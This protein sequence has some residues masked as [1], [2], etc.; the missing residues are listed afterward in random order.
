MVVEELLQ[1]LV[2]EVNACWFDRTRVSWWSVRLGTPAAV[3]LQSC[4]KP[5]YCGVFDLRGLFRQGKE[6]ES[7]EG[8]REAKGKARKDRNR[9]K[10]KRCAGKW[11]GKSEARVRQ[12]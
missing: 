5:L 4:S 3:Y 9:T 1:L 10:E 2:S 11:R 7:S 12:E 6:F 8:Q